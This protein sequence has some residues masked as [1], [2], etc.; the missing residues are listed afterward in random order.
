MRASDDKALQYAIAEIT[1]IATGFGLDFY[2]MRYEICPAEII[3]TFGAYGMPTRF[4]HW[5]FGKQFFRM[6]LQYDLG[7]SKIYELVINSD[8]CYAFLLDTNSLIQNK[9][10]VAHVLAHC[11]FFKNN[12]RFSNTK[13]D[14]VESMS[15]TAERVKAYEHKYGKEEVETFLDA[16]LAIQEHI[17]PSLMRPKLAWS[18]DDLEEVEKKKVSQYDDLWNLDDRNKRRERSNI[19]KKK[20]IPPQPEKDLLLFIEEYSRELEDWQRDILTMMREEM[21]YF[22]PQLETK[23]MNEGWAS[24]WHQRILREMDLTSDEAIEFAKLN[25]GVVQPSKTSINPYYLGI[26]MFEDIEERYNNPTEEM[27][28]RGVKPGSGRDKMF[29]V[30]EIEW[31]VS[32]LRNYLNKD[33]VMRE[34]MYLFQRQGKEYKVIDKEWE[35]VR[36]QLVNMRT[37]G[38]FPYL[39]VED[40]DYLKNGELYIKHSYE[41]IELD[42]KYL[43]KVLPY[44][45]QLWGRTV[46][47]ESIVESKGVVFSYDGK[48]VHRKYV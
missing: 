38:G 45:H 17:D 39:V 15:A 26:K 13:R 14:M 21:L 22:W 20:K 40:G 16:V 35:N 10:I 29:E 48:M 1:E 23:I 25:A 30:R 44:L 11:D 46:H 36:D 47:M 37:N 24:Y 3:Y 6:K 32:F 4:S 9:L 42:L 7:L 43:E 31:D 34:D 2:P 41:G 5:S 12:I 27:K 28:R 18:I 19:R 33:L 8:P